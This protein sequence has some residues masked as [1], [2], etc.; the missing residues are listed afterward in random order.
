MQ[1]KC[2]QTASDEMLIRA[3]SEQRVWVQS[4]IN[5]NTFDWPQWNSPCA[6]F[7]AVDR[8]RGESVKSSPHRE[9]EPLAEKG[10]GD[11]TLYFPC[12]R[13]WRVTDEADECVPLGGGGFSAT[14]FPLK[15]FS[16]SGRMRKSELHAGAEARGVRDA[17]GFYDWDKCPLLCSIFAVLIFH[18]GGV[19]NPLKYIT[20]FPWLTQGERSYRCLGL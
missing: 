6:Y 20:L 5:Q 15:G 19:Y 13:G 8:P 10:A 3:H 17:L 4:A 14:M 16:C 9:T 7:K 18:L 2:L 12:F 1:I 11:I